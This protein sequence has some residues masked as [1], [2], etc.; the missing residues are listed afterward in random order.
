MRKR[1]IIG[2]FILMI[3]SL[4]F[5][6]PVGAATRTALVIGNSKYKTAPLQNPVNDA[7]DMAKSLR[8]LNFDVIEKLNAGKRD[9]VL[10][11]DEFYKRLKRADVGVFYF[12]G[13]GMQ[14]HGVN[15]LIPVKAHVTSETD[16]QFEAVDA[17]RV[18][19]KMR[20]ASNKLNLV[21][22]DACRDNPFKRSFRTDRKGLA[23]MDAPK[24]TIV[25][26][27]TSPGSVAADGGGRNGIYTK[28]LLKNIKRSDLSVQ[29]VFM[30]TGL[31][32][33]VETNEQQVPWVSSTPVQK[34]Y[35]DGRT[36]LQAPSH[37]SPLHQIVQKSQPQEL[38]D[39]YLTSDPTEAVVYLNGKRMGRTPITLEQIPAGK[40]NLVLR[41]GY[42]V[43][44]LQVN[45]APDDLV[46]KQVKLEYQKGEL[47][48]FTE[49]SGARVYLDGKTIGESPL[50]ITDVK[51][52]EHT[53]EARLSENNV[54]YEYKERVVVKP[55]GNRFNLTL[56]KRL[57]KAGDTWTDPVTG[58][59]FVFV[60]DGC[61]QMGS[62]SGASDE[63]PVHEVCV[64]GFWM[65]KYEV[66]QGQWEKVM[67][68][69]PSDFKKGDNYPV[70]QVSWD[71]AKGFIGKL[72]SLNNGQFK[73]RLPTEAEWE[74]ACRSGGKPEKD[75]W[76]NDVDSIAWYGNNSGSSTHPVG[77]KAPNALGIY[78]MS[79]NVWEW[80]E[81]IY[82]ENAYSKH[83]R[84]NPIYTSGGSSRVLRGGSWI[85]SPRFVRC[86]DRDWFDPGSRYGSLGFRLVRPAK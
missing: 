45:L 42:Q 50:K 10:A 72:N 31:G 62:S 29:D 71:D 76:G 46:K 22:L 14:I 84:N 17:G 82:S 36:S 75:A 66:T 6:H 69:N 4:A 48:V 37:S 24:G 73:F 57:L 78:D 83:Q 81:D 80:C 23:Q 60:P 38:A 28:H 55:K 18:L 59:E 8:S 19:G 34:Y 74:Y 56:E 41:K 20:E 5:L 67:G 53:L 58:I 7:R 27:A 1:I 26:Y 21:I 68:N 3:C 47:K 65:G 70:E 35:L 12:A 9:M 11:I 86:A 30:E 63:K 15:Y 64:D 2:V 13:H 16:I 77:T 40:H 51:A 43:A 79:G 54:V 39:L 85:D 44:K 52:G 25:A 33:M 32:V 61:Y 49:P